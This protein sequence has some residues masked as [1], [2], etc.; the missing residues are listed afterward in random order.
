MKIL[1]FVPVPLPAV[2]QQLDLPHNGGGWWIESLMTALLRKSNVELGVVWSSRDIY[3]SKN[4]VQNGV[5]YYCLP[6]TPKWIHKLG[7]TTHLIDVGRFNYKLT[8]SLLDTCLR[9]VSDFKPDVIHVHGSERPYGLITERIGTPVILSIQSILNEYIKFYFGQLK[10]AQR[11]KIPGLF[12]SYINMSRRAKIERRIFSACNYFCGRTEWDK[13][14]QAILNPNGR[15][16]F[17]G[18]LIRPEFY[19]YRWSIDQAVPYTIYTTTSC[20]PYKGVDTL[21]DAVAILRH[22]FP[23]VRLRISGNIPTQGYGRFLRRKART[24][25]LKDLVKFLGWLPAEKIAKEL[26]HANIFIIPSFI[27]NSPNSLAEAQLVGTP[28]V[29]SSAGGITSMVIDNETGLLFPPG[30]ATALAMQIRRMFEDIDL[31]LQCSEH[32][33]QVAFAR[34][35]HEKVIASVMRMYS[36]VGQLNNALTNGHKVDTLN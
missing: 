7:K 5:Y 17:C 36:E 22:S 20:L 9:A 24:L 6:G 34:H 15:Y 25:K 8:K 16:F 3:Q 28:V 21:L 13:S 35:D 12:Y 2:C 19:R 32:A 14:H 10:F 18:E 31:A 1:W 23:Y 30:D 27:E 33:R 11:I 29:A 26:V 4:F